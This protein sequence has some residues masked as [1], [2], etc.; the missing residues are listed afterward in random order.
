[1]SKSMAGR[2]R[3]VLEVGRVRNMRYGLGHRSALGMSVRVLDF[4]P[5]ARVDMS[6]R[7]MVR[8]ALRGIGARDVGDDEWEMP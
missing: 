3:R 7:E 5:Q 2:P 8:E 6:A 4:D 1:M